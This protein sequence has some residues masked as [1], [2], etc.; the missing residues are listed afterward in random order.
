MALVL[1]LLPLNHDT[2]LVTKLH[3]EQGNLVAQYQ[4][5]YSFRSVAKPD[6]D[7]G[8]QD[9]FY[10]PIIHPQVVSPVATAPA[11]VAG[12]STISRNTSGTRGTVNPPS[13][14]PAPEGYYHTSARH[15]A[16]HPP[17]WENVE[18]QP[19]PVGLSS[20]IDVQQPEA[21]D[22][23]LLQKVAPIEGPTRGGV[24]I[25]LIGTNLPAW[26]TAVYARFGSA[27][28]ATVSQCITAIFL[29]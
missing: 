22:Q 7:G 26:P 24:N 8:L 23:P 13:Q 12:P 21:S 9:D 4:L 15:A 29:L 14:R 25:V 20:R 17:L 16:Q 19:P 10:P 11:P 28:A 3:D 2:R 27:V 1:Y 18:T 5:P 6:K